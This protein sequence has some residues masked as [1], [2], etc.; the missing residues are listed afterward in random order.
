MVPPTGQAVLDGELSTDGRR[1]RR[2][3]NREAVVDALAALH[4]EGNLQP[5]AAEIAAR[6]GLSPRSLFRYFDDVADLSQA[7]IERQ[8]ALA[9]PLAHLPA[10][11]GLPLAERTDLVVSHRVALYDEIAPAA[12]AA[13]VTAFRLPVVARQVAEARRNLRDQL[14]TVFAPELAAA[15]GAAADLLASL[16]V[17][18]SFESYELLS[19]NE[20]VGRD[21]LAD[22]LTAG[23]RRLLHGPGNR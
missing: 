21:R 3:H 6:A 20:G 18:F 10:T 7:A 14:G 12:R 16:D 22:V 17:L 5:S 15:G 9:L 2:A 8:I 1:A 11:D 23:A 13:R 4:R 19:A